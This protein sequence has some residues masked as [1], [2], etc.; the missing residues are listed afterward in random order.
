MDGWLAVD[1]DVA[2]IPSSAKIKYAKLAMDVY[3]YQAKR[4]RL[5]SPI[6]D[7]NFKIYFT[8]AYWKCDTVLGKVME[9][10]LL[11]LSD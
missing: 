3:I 9:E 10:H 8:G 11:H 1:K 2:R 4:Q 7:K 5:N 6:S